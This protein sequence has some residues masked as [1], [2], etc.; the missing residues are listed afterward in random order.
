MPKIRSLKPPNLVNERIKIFD[1]GF[2]AGRG[3]SSKVV[4]LRSRGLGDVVQLLPSLRCMKRKYGENVKLLFATTKVYFPL[5]KRFKFIDGLREADSLDRESFDIVIDLDGKFD[6]LPIC[7]QA[8]RADLISSLLD[9]PTECN[10]EE[11]IFPVT[12][13]ERRR[14]KS[15]LKRSGWEGEPLLGLH[16]SAYAPIRT[17]PLERNIELVKKL[18]KQKILILENRSIR[19][20]FKDFPNVILPDRTE[21]IDLIGLITMCKCIV[22]PDSGVLHLAGF[23]KV[24]TVALFGPIPP[25]FRI[26]YYPTVRAICLGLKCSPCWDWQTHACLN[27]PWYR[28]CLK[29]I[30]PEMVAKEL[31]ELGCF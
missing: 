30:T 17:W 5:F 22:C 24:P 19:E 1:L 28:D 8:P 11:F 27:T 20:K 14:A 6:F 18:R 2:A 31:E 13:S 10:S 26:K 25:E 9:V 29:K 16:L 3:A 15:S 4:V 21:L 7:K 12:S 23:L